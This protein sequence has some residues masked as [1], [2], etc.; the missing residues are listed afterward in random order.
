MS[1]NLSVHRAMFA[2]VIARDFVALR[3][4]YHPDYTY[5]GGDGVEQKGAEAGLEVAQG[6]TAA[7][8]DL[9]FEF[10][11]EFAVDDVTSVI[12]F[13]A[14]GTHQ[15]ALDDIPATGRRVELVACN[16]VEVR[17]GQIHRE[18]EYF[19]T[20]SLLTQLGAV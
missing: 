13:T 7:F 5:T 17:D 4:L 6:Y 8:P 19:D 18:R 14:R 10:R 11:H 15:G 16:V 1:S 2:A 9:T 12:E 3:A 20:M